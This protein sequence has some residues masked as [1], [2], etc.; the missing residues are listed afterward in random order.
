MLSLP[1][2]SWHPV[3][4]VR[5]LGSADIVVTGKAA[6]TIE[7]FVDKAAVAD[8]D[9]QIAKWNGLV[10]LRINGSIPAFGAKIRQRF[11]RVASSWVSGF[12][13]MAASQMQRSS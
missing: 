4:S 9:R 8:S 7:R 6:K 12:S 11:H 3:G 13:P 10:C 2:Q 1:E 5:N